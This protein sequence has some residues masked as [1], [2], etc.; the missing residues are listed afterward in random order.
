MV[1]AVA[2]AGV[3]KTPHTQ[4]MPG[5]HNDYQYVRCSMF[6]FNLQEDTIKYY[7]AI[8]GAIRSLWGSTII[9]PYRAQQEVPHQLLT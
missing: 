6:M 2:S 5:P 9:S 4:T 8:Q 3:I 1:G 7:L